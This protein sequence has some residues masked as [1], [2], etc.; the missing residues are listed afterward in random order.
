MVTNC[1]SIVGGA[2]TPGCVALPD[3]R[4]SQG[5]PNAMSPPTVTPT[6]FLTLP[7]QLYSNAP[8]VVA[9]DPQY[10]LPTVHQWNLSIQRELPMGFLAQVAYV[11]HRGTRLQRAYDLNQI[12]AAPIIP[13]FQIMQSNYNLGCKPDG[14]GCPTGITGTPVPIVVSGAIP[15]SLVSTVINSSTTIGYLTTNA[16]GSF[17]SRIEQNTLNLHLRPNQ[18]F[19]KITYIDSGGD[20]YYHAFQATLRKRFDKGLLFGLSYT[21]GKSI[22]DQ[23]VD[24][25]GASSSGGL[26]TSNSRT[27]TDIR[28]WRNE[29][30]R[31]DFDRRNVLMINAVYDLPVG[32]GKS[33][34]GNMPSVLNHVFGGWSVNGIYTAQSGEPFS[35]T[36]GTFT[37]NASHYSRA[38][39]V[40]AQPTAQLQQLPGIPGPSYF[41]NASAFVIPAPG[42]NGI[43]RNVFQAPGYWN[44]DLGIAKKFDITERIKLNFR[45]EMFNALNHPNF[46]NPVAA[47]VGLPSI[48]SSVFAES[49][50]Q[51]VAVPATQTI[52]QTGES[53][54]IIQFALKLSF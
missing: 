3:L 27:P 24:P 23:S 50:C 15:T 6:S 33:L 42:S 48:R 44:L 41:A 4:I 21:Y 54:R 9:I 7:A 13:S 46:D 28:N 49:C 40:G 8:A 22:D 30:G 12:S 31:S 36:S 35:V 32:R 10:K 5:F 14:T 19:N 37:Q 47:S 17:A 11:G 51:T 25:I 29:R 2:T 52:I 43:G 45:M 1:S 18:Q 26:S 16:A 20:S 39:L 38:S 34:G 53:A